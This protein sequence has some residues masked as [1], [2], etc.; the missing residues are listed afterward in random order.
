MSMIRILHSRLSS[1][2]NTQ[3]PLK[4]SSH[5]FSKPHGRSSISLAGI[6]QVHVGVTSNRNIYNGIRAFCTTEDL[7][8]KKCVPCNTKD[9]RPMTEEAANTLMS[10]V[11]EWSLVN[12]GGILKLHRSWKVKTFIKGLN[13]FELV[14]CLAETEGH[15]PDLH[16]VGWNNVKI[17]IWTHAVGGLTEND[18]I[19]AV[20]IDRLNVKELLR[21]EV[22]KPTVP[23][24]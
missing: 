5:G 2:S 18:F 13:F 3:V 21:R 14:G 7:S 15:H 10:Q 11:P 1:L 6:L 19:L 22:A 23:S 20:K 24:S 4:A 12:D 17:D 16:L 8:I 9:L